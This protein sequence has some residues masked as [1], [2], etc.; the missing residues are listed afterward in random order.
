MHTY[1]LHPRPLLLIAGPAIDTGEYNT[2]TA[3]KLIERVAAE[4]AR[5]YT[6]H[7]CPC[8]RLPEQRVPTPR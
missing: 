4:I 3:G 8:E 7:A 2:K 6:E 1:H 5:M